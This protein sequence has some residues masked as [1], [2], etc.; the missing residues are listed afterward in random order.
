MLFKPNFSQ[1]Y[2]SA[3]YVR[4]CDEDGNFIDEIL[5][6]EAVKADDGCSSFIWKKEG[7]E[8]Y[9][10]LEAAHNDPNDAF[11]IADAD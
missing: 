9:E 5:M 1:I 4:K 2:T 7:N 3:K 10:A 11:T 8:Y 6:I